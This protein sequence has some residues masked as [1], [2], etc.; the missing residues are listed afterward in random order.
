MYNVTVKSTNVN[1]KPLFNEINEFIEAALTTSGIHWTEDRHRGALADIVV[2]WMQ[3]FVAEGKIT[4]FKCIADDRNNPSD[5]PS[6]EFNV[7]V[8]YKQKHCLNTTT[9]HY[10]LKDDIHNEIDDLLDWVLAP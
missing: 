6:D 5:Q 9:I 7:L 3:E 4:Q 2:E 10:H 1:S 8:T